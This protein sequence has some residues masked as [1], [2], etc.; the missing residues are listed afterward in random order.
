[1]GET[2]YEFPREVRRLAR[3]P[4]CDAPVWVP[5]RPGEHARHLRVV[6]GQVRTL[7]C[8]DLVRR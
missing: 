2:T 7:S 1:M 8:L 4:D 3:C 6:D 5:M